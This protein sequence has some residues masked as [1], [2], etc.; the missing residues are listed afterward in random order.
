MSHK[1]QRPYLT[2]GRLPDVVA[3]IQVLG[4]DEAA[5]RSESGLREEL[6]RDPS[7]TETWTKVATDHPEFFRVRPG[8]DHAVSLLAR[9]VT[10]KVEGSRPPLGADHVKE[11]IAVALSIHDRELEQSRSWHVWLPLAGVVVGAAIAGVLGV[12]I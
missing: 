10:P 9:H 8:G 2:P 4:F 7:S 12:V 3:L 11:L 6:Q 1:P 5:H